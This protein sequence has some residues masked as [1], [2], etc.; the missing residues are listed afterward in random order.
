MQRRTAEA[1]LAAAQQ[2][3]LGSEAVPAWPAGL[4]ERE[5]EVLRRRSHARSGKLASRNRPSSAAIARASSR[6]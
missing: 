4:T 2:A 5:V 6:V 3:P 1:V